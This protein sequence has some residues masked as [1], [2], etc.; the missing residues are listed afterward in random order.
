MDVLNNRDIICISSVD[1]EPIWTRKQQIMSR[2]PKSN[3]I[4]YVEPPISCLSRFKDPGV[5]F[6][7]DRA[8]EGVRKHDEN[9]WLLSPP[10]ILPFG[11]KYPGFNK[12]NQKLIADS[13]NKAVKQLGFKNPVVWTYL[14]TSCDLVEAIERSLTV[15]DC[16]DEHAAY[17]G[18]NSDLV[19]R[20][21]KQ[22]IQKCDMVFCTAQ[23]LYDD[24]KPFAK[25]IH[26]SPNAADVEH[27]MKASDPE[28]PVADELAGLTGPVFGFV[29]FIKEWVDLELIADLAKAY[30]DGHVVMVGPVGAGIDMSALKALPNVMILGHRDRSELPRYIKAFS[31]C[32]NAFKLNELTSTV[33]PLKFYEYLASGIPVAS[34]PMPEI[35]CFSDVVEFGGG[36]EGF[37]AAVARALDDNDL[38]KAARLQ[39]A[40]ENSWQ[41]RADFM[42]GKIAAKLKDKELKGR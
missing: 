32:L 15:Y 33:S 28:L 4:L 36:K 24:R 35:S 7:H 37:I 8:R 31:V 26:F 38:K 14:H 25:E 9:L 6:K 19:K 21:E 30:P 20:M 1:W 12:I 42:A 22:L 27:F 13:I 3:R 29:G 40:S 5:A 11:S 2:L 10:V 17:D 23:G 41:S 39:R 16:V 18:F 34:V